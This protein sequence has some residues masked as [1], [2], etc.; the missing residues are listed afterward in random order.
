MELSRTLDKI[1]ACEALSVDSFLPRA[2]LRDASSSSF[3][4]CPIAWA[5]TDAAVLHDL[6]NDGDT[7]RSVR[8]F[9]MVGADTKMRMCSLGCSHLVF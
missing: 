3:F 5:L 8:M 2:A 1:S 6:L 7:A 4:S 9:A